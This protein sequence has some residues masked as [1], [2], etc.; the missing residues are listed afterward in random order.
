MEI[1]MLLFKV[2]MHE[3]FDMCIFRREWYRRRICTY[4]ILLNR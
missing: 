2:K 3:L 4:E 1:G